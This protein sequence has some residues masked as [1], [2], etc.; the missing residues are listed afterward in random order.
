MGSP[1]L[2]PRI[3]LVRRHGEARHAAHDTH[4]RRAA[5]PIP[6]APCLRHG[7][8]YPDAPHCACRTLDAHTAPVRLAPV[9]TLA[10]LV[11]MLVVL[12]A[13]PSSSHTTTATRGQRRPRRQRREDSSNRWRRRDGSRDREDSGDGNNIDPMMA[14][15]ETAAVTQDDCRNNHSF[16]V[17]TSYLPCTVHSSYKL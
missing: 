4:P 2:P 6:P 14:V 3:V 5:K 12:H 17:V 16:P 7:L 15:T 10:V 11:M 1:L 9:G 13:M 8:S